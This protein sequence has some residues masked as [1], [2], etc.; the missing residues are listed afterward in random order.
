M[1]KEQIMEI[2]PHRDDM[3]LVD[4]IFL[5]EDGIAHGSYH[6]RGDEWFLRGH[7]PANPVV[8]GV[9]LCEIM[10]QAC[11]ML[12]NDKLAGNTAYYTGLDKVRFKN[13]VLPG[14]TVEVSAVFVKSKGPFYFTH[15]VARVNG[16]LCCEGDLSFVVT[17]G[18]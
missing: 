18:R 6:V 4:D 12:L 1:N 11:A 15:A 14:D 17:E 9:I 8:P 16:K 10:G 2:L 5:G 3:L 7:F 13:K